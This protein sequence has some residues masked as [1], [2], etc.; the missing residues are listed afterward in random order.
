MKTLLSLLLVFCVTTPGLAAA[1]I[2]VGR[3]SSCA[4]IL[5][6]G[7]TLEHAVVNRG[8]F[9]HAVCAIGHDGTI[10]DVTMR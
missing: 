10:I 4:V 2:H 1:R 8:K 5:H 6:N 3:A 7:G 9:R